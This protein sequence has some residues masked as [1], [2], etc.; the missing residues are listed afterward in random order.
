MEQMIDILMDAA[1]DVLKLIPFL[2]LTYWCMEYLEHRA[3]DKMNRVV[4]RAGRLGPV[5]G[6]LLGIIPQ[7]GFSA[8]AS[9]FYAGRIISLGTLIAIYLSTSDE[10]LP[11]LLSEQVSPVLIG[12]LVGFKALMGIVMGLMIDFLY[13]GDREHGHIHDICEHEHCGCEKSIL[14]SALKHTLQIAGFLFLIGLVLGGVLELAGE[15]A[16]AGLILDRPF[17]GPVLAGL[18]GLIPN[19]ASS[20]VIT[21]LYLEQALGMGA[22]LAGLLTNAGVGVLVLFRVNAHKKENYAILGLLY[23]IG[24]VTGIIVSLVVG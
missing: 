20:V 10:M 8:A 22:M 21:K 5:A 3:S 11:I 19:C 13:K 14:R 23:G 1:L 2:F 7:C 9:N 16:I 18:V 6:G 4:Q 17:L 15:E 24:V 12:K